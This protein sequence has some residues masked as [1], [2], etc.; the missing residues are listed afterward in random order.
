[1]G[2]AVNEPDFVNA[3]NDCIDRLNAGERLEDCLRRYPRHAAA[4]RPLLMAGQSVRQAQADPYTV[5][6]ARARVRGRIELAAARPIRGARRR[7]VWSPLALAASLVLVLAAVFAGGSA[8]LNSLQSQPTPTMIVLPSATPSEQPNLTATPTS[9]GT[10]SETPTPTLTATPT[11]T[12]TGTSSPSATPSPSRTPPLTATQTRTPSPTVCVPTRPEG[13]IDY[14]VQAGDTV[15]GLAAS[16]G[17]SMDTLRQ[18]NCVEGGLIR[19]GQTVYLP[20]QPAPASHPASATPAPSG[21]PGSGGGSSG[22]SGGTDN[23]NDNVD[24]DNDN[25]DDHGGSSNS[26]SGSGDDHS[27]DD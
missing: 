15:S 3:L 9:S 4:L 7:P 10:P 20:M 8:V 12:P 11:L 1:M 24:D 26:G 5:A 27:S 17:I 21:D 13:W 22:G 19:V 25:M 23:T 18:V 16:T 6:A 2:T 14:R